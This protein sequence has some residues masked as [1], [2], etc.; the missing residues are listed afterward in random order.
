[1]GRRKGIFIGWLADGRDARVLTAATFVHSVGTG[2]FAA[3]SA[4]FFTRSAG[5][6]PGEVGTGM[7]LAG[8]VAVG[9]ALVAGRLAD[10]FGARD[11]LVG[12]TT[13][14]AALVPLYGA[15]HDLGRFLVVICVLTAAD[16]GARV[17]RDTVI[18]GLTGG[19]D[20]VRVKGHL[21]T[22]AKIGV[23]VGALAA[24]VPLQLGTRPAY[25]AMILGNALA[26]ALTA[27]LSALLPRHRPAPRRTGG[28]A[29][30]DLP[31]L[32]VAVLCGL[33]ATY[34]SLLTIALPLWVI[35]RTDAPDVTVAV[36][37]GG[38]TLLSVALQVPLTRRAGAGTAWRG[39]ALIGP[40]CVLIALSAVAPAGAAVA[41]LAVAVAV[42]T[43][44]EL[45]TSLAAW[46]LNFDL[47]D[48]REP[49][50]YQGMFSLGMSVEGV[51]GPLLATGVVL[52]LGVPGWLLAGLLSAALGGAVTRAA[53]WARRTRPQ[54]A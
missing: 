30:R 28:P 6:R 47:A 15:V 4:M 41:L 12:L 5:L 38:H 45:L 44:S 2:S 24:V 23:S 32:S 43:V 17:A 20:R 52:G 39:A 35:T 48:S 33:Q 53:G 16:H 29:T 10:R 31:Y 42:L 8:F 49:G 9:A 50:R 54:P 13:A 40:A 51:A 26:A 27:A 46:A 14:Q 1:M 22:A 21:R 36:L 7:A 18:A 25:L 19:V 37:L 3:G 34:R 11:L